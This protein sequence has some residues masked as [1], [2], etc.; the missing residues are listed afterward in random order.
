MKKNLTFKKTVLATSIALLTACGGSGSNTTASADGT[1]VG[2]VTGFGSVYINGVEYETDSASI[3][4]DGI[5]SQETELGVGDKCILEGT[6]NPDGLT[7]VAT[8]V[9]C[10]DELE[11]YVLSVTLAADG[12]G[13]IDVMG[14]SVSITLDTVFDSD[15]YA[16]ITELMAD[17]IVEIHGFSDGAGT[18]V[19]TRV[20][21]KD[22]NDHDIEI[23]GLVSNLGASTF[24]IG[25]LIV[26]F[27][28]A[29][30][31]PVLTDGLYVEV[32][33]DAA[34]SDTGSG[35]TLNA[36]KIEIEDD[37]DMDIDG[38]EGDDFEVTGLVSSVT[39]TSFIFNG[40]TLVEF[41]SLESD[42]DFDFASITDGMMITVEGYIDAEGNFVVEE[43]EEDHSSE[44]EAEGMVSEVTADSVTIDI[45]GDGSL[46]K[47]FII[48]NDTRMIDDT[49]AAPLHYF[50]LADV[51]VGNYVEVEY[52]IDDASG[53]MI[54]TELELEDT[55]TV[56]ALP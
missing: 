10:N 12:T 40:T 42:D 49:D 8:S 17:D 23:K 24:T 55:P 14:Q 29:T 32:K 46:L 20:E 50:S 36:T 39:D 15:T 13:T 38:D 51:V 56:T 11:G 7:G 31:L 33:S 9:S 21:T 22:A 35:M 43:I 16:S 25:T 48:N 2:V 3:T 52:Y 6:V 44:E 34:P 41:A 1:T 45:S 37:G 19:A 47:T 4:I 53:D 28:N 18:V 27:S 5:P 54:A 26:D 30:E